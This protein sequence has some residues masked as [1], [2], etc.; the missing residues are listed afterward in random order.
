MKKY[1]FILLVCLFFNC[2]E[3]EAKS[4]DCLETITVDTGNVIAGITESSLIDNVKLIPLLNAKNL[5]NKIGKLKIINDVVFVSDMNTHI[6]CFF[7][8]ED[9]SY[10]GKINSR[11]RG[12]GEY[13]Q[14]QDFYVNKDLKYVEILDGV[15]KKILRY[16]LKGGFVSSREVPYHFVSFSKIN[17]ENN[18]VFCKAIVSDDDQWMYQ[19]FLTDNN[20]N[21]LNKYVKIEKN[22]TTDI[23]L[24][25]TNSLQSYDNIISFQ[26][27]Y[28]PVIYTIDKKLN[29]Q[30]RYCLDFLGSWIDDELAYNEKKVDALDYMKLI[31]NSGKAYFVDFLEGNKDVIIYFRMKT[32]EE[33]KNNLY[34]NIYNKLNKSSMLYNFNNSFFLADKYHTSYK[35]YF[36]IVK[37]SYE[38]KEYLDKKPD[39]IDDELKPVILQSNETGDPLLMLTKFK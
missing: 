22:K 29:L 39:E 28:N 24:G 14:I 37:Q 11:G 10:L 2:N 4:E 6:V 30:H 17:D 5:I 3:K 25:P 21:I 19:L 7:S 26:P 33:N 38:L 31:A 9:G 32:K 13:S 20:L 15:S 35:D 36:V 1:I 27:I 23:V 8:L 12:A 18:F 16:D 34:I